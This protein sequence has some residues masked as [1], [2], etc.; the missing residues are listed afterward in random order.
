MFHIA[1]FCKS[2][3]RILHL[4]KIVNCR[5]RSFFL[6]NYSLSSWIIHFSKYCI[7]SFLIIFCNYCKFAFG[8]I[9]S[10]KFATCRLSASCKICKLYILIFATLWF[11]RVKTGY[12]GLIWKCQHWR[13]RRLSLIDSA[14]Q[15]LLICW[16]FNQT[17]PRMMKSSWTLLTYKST[18]S[19]D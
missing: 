19:T 17:S 14:T 7:S 6:Q 9:F 2:S 10:S 3:F 15:P 18:D 1:F 5:S 8:V 13:R 11:A 4:S 16:S 12:P